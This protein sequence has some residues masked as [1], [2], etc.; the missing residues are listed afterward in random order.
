MENSRF[1]I[2]VNGSPVLIDADGG[3]KEVS[4]KLATK[5]LTE[6]EA[7]AVADNI[8]GKVL[9]MRGRKPFE[10]KKKQEILAIGV[11][12]EQIEQA[13]GKSAMRNLIRDWVEERFSAPSTSEGGE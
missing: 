9:A 11:R 4:V 2:K 5:Y 3:L 12:K 10:D 6:N 7:Q 1:Y 13:G 8:G